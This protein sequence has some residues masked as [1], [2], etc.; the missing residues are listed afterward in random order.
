MVQ[1]W[2]KTVILSVRRPHVS[3]FAQIVRIG[4]SW[5]LARLRLKHTN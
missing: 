1:H 3:A 4:K 2:I 5:K